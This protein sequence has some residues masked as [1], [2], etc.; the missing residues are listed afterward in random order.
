MPATSCPVSEIPDPEKAAEPISLPILMRNT[1]TASSEKAQDRSE[2]DPAKI[3]NRLRVDEFYDRLISGHAC[4]EENDQHDQHA[5]HVLSL[6]ITV[7][8]APT[9]SLPCQR[10]SNPER[11]ARSRIGEDCDGSAS[12]ATEP[13]RN[14]MTNWSVAVMPNPTRKTFNAQMPVHSTPLPN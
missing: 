8:K 12:K 1:A 5:C 11:N 10:K 9:G 14:T 3:R 2:R 4:R 13:D 7:G 6:A